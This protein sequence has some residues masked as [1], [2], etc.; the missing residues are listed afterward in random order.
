MNYYLY[1]LC[2]RDSVHFGSSDSALSLQASADHFCADTLFSALC[3]T[4][5]SL[6]GEKGIGSLCEQVRAGE[7]LL[8][9]SMPWRTQKG[10]DIFYL[11]KPC[12]VSSKKQDVPVELRKTMKR[13]TWIPVQD[14]ADFRASLEGEQPYTPHETT[15]GVC[16]MRTMAAV[17]DGEDTR[18]YQ[19]GVFRFLPS[20]GL[21]FLVGCKREEQAK[22][23]EKMIH[24]LGLGGIGGK[25]S[26][27][28]GTYSVEDMI[29]LNEPFDAQTQWLY[30]ALSFTE[31]KH[32]LLLTTSLPADNELDTVLDG[33]F[34]QLAR[35]GG[36]V[37]SDTF[38]DSPQRKR[39][40]FFLSA[41]AMLKKPFAGELFCVAE[42]DRHP[43]Y[44]YSK[45]LMLGV[46]F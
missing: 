44:R 26:A 41:G 8:S 28:F 15:F 33:A 30:D 27:G 3:H 4:A 35:R 16:E 1:K 12:M 46:A 34:Y 42:N 22:Q 25:V 7:L 36:Y 24:A 10:E 20:C 2:F 31:I 39:T 37:Q 19:V 13:L 21:Y 43:V 32:Y 17:K 11:P 14:M 40:Q 38:S 5:G 45:P 23:L 18:P 6:W 9:D 29:F